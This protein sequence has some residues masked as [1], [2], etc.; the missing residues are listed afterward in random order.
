MSFRKICAQCNINPVE[1]R[2]DDAIYCGNACKVAASKQRRA[3][4]AHAGRETA[5]TPI[6]AAIG[7]LRPGA[8]RIL[9]SLEAAPRHQATTHQL[10]DGRVGGHRFSAYVWEIRMELGP[11]GVWIDKGPKLANGQHVYTLRL[12]Q[13]TLDV[14]APAAG[15]LPGSRTGVSSSRPRGGD[16]GT[17][18]RAA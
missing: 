14:D 17:D 11:L 9:R 18:R 15:R 5:Q 6:E 7:K 4:A 3:F 13:L 10:R 2:R 8:R 12:P 16:V 1:G